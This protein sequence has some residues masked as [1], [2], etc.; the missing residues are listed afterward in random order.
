MSGRDKRLKAR[1]EQV[2][3]STTNIVAV[4]AIIALVVLHLFSQREVPQFIDWGLIG[5]A[6]GA[7]IDDVKTWFGGGK[8]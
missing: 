8:A 5:A 1:K 6:L 4:T 2:E 7:K 3:K